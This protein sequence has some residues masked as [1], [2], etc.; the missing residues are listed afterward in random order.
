MRKAIATIYRTFADNGIDLPHF[1]TIGLLGLILFIHFAQIS[2]IFNI[3]LK[4]FIL[5][6]PS[7]SKASQWFFA[8]VYFALVWFILN[9]LFGE[10]KLKEV[11]VT[12]KEVKRGRYILWIYFSVNFL[13]LLSLLVKLGIEKG[14]IK[15]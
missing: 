7:S 11:V 2:L 15:I 9:L 5:W 1:R 3:D 4:Y 6:N 12:E 14:T 8:A 10:S 13:V